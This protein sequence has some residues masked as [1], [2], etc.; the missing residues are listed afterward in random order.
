MI[1]DPPISPASAIAFW[2][3]SNAPVKHSMPRSNGVTNNLN[4]RLFSTVPRNCWL[5][6]RWRD[7]HEHHLE[8][9]PAD[10]AANRA[11][12]RPGHP[13]NPHRSPNRDHGFA[14]S[15]D[16]IRRYQP[17]AFAGQYTAAAQAPGVAA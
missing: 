5:I 2:G 16:G 3:R 9:A 17:A 12:A 10:G 4:M 15:F 11:D 1:P 13:E 14:R 6:V 8:Y 7:R